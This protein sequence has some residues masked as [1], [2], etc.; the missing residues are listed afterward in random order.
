MAEQ[1]K[2][3][4]Y[5]VM[6]EFV[7]PQTLLDAVHRAQAAGYDAMDA[8]TPY[9]VEPVS[10]AIEHHKRSKVPLLVLL[11]AIAGC[12]VAFFGQW[13]ISA[14]D[15]PLNIGGRPLFSWPAFIPATFELTILFA[16]FAAVFGMFLLNGLPKPYH[17]VFNVPSFERASQDRC[18]LLIESRDP[19]FDPQATREFLA[20]LGPE[21]VHDVD[22]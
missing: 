13:W 10:E 11:G 4:L 5:G 15:Y 9:P 16:A 7:S 6:A 2:E 14:V 8:F 12:S 3:G 18:F 1:K 20:Q 17:P 22:W 21:E 19:K